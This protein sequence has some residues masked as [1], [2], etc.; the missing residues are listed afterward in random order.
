MLNLTKYLTIGNQSMMVRRASLLSL[1]AFPYPVNHQYFT[2]FWFV[3]SN[4][5]INHL[6]YPWK[7]IVLQL[8]EDLSHYPINIVII[9]PYVPPKW[10]PLHKPYLINLSVEQNLSNKVL[11]FKSFLIVS[12]LVFYELP[13]SLLI[14]SWI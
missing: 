4:S 8:K 7:R 5:R 11:I 1:F 9:K 2:I 12:N 6:A 3:L 13:L 14:V 10:A